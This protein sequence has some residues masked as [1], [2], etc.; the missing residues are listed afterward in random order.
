M[1]SGTRGGGQAAFAVQLL[2]AYDRFDPSLAGGISEKAELHGD[3]FKKCFSQIW[4]AQGGAG[5]FHPILTLTVR[6]RLR[7]H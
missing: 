5:K 1:S 7:V 4:Q 3:F 2:L 6:Q